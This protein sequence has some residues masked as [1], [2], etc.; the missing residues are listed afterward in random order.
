MEY[1]QVVEEQ[2]DCATE[3]HTQ[4]VPPADPELNTCE[5]KVSETDIPNFMDLE[6]CDSVNEARAQG[7]PSSD[8]EPRACTEKAFETDNVPQE[9]FPISIDVLGP[10]KERIII[11]VAE[12]E[13]QHDAN[14]ETSA[15]EESDSDCIIVEHVSQSE[16]YDCQTSES[17]CELTVDIPSCDHAYSHPVEPV[18]HSA[19]VMSS[20]NEYPSQASTDFLVNSVQAKSSNVTTILPLPSLI[21]EPDSYE[22]SSDERS[23][24]DEHPVDGASV[25][26]VAP[27]ELMDMG[28]SGLDDENGCSVIEN[29]SQ[30]GTDFSVHSLQANGYDITAILPLPSLITEPDSDELSS[31]EWEHFGYP[32]VEIVPRYD[33]GE[34]S[35]LERSHLSSEVPCTAADI[36]ALS[37]VAETHCD[38]K[39][40]DTAVASTSHRVKASSVTDNDPTYFS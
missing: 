4:A 35:E 25:F 40:S 15:G 31:C 32:V 16:A 21:R 30:A 33:E 14:D 2:Y 10:E 19:V 22:L 5:N 39:S 36:S 9:C 11:Q 20:C 13:I 6:Q 8:P 28:I 37:S 7:M 12:V 29:T 24:N 26:G 3:N 18:Q 1:K 17:E 34:V 38:N 23:Q 27:M